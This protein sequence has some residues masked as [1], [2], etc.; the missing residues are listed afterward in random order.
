MY[1][2]RYLFKYLNN[3]KIVILVIY[4]M[5]INM[6]V[7]YNYIILVMYTSTHNSS[8]AYILPHIYFKCCHCH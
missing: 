2:K 8:A 7:M 5:L 4:S 3:N 1:S 6:F